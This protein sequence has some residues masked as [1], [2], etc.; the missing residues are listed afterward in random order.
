VP[1]TIE[2]LIGYLR[3]T[4]GGPFSDSGVTLYKNHVMHPL[5]LNKV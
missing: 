5:N 3:L 2:P 1:Y 4:K